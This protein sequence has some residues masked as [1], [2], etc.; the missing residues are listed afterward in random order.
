MAVPFSIS[1]VPSLPLLS[2]LWGPEF[3]LVI[4]TVE[5]VPAWGQV[6]APGLPCPGSVAPKSSHS[7]VPR[8]FTVST[9]C[10]V[11]G[12]WAEMGLAG[13]EGQDADIARKVTGTWET[14]PQASFISLD[15]KL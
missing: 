15:R 14:S 4:V 8:L 12:Q 10:S 2:C 13:T 3:S 1:C 11:A 7:Q 5:R 6:P 9:T